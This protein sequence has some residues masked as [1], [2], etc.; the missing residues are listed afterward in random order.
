[1][2]AVHPTGPRQCEQKHT[3]TC[4]RSPWLTHRL[5]GPC[6]QSFNTIF[7][8]HFLYFILFYLIFWDGISLLLD[9]A[10]VQWCD[11]G[12]LQPPPPGSSNFPASASWVAGF[13]DTTHHAW[14]IFII[15]VETGFHHIGQAS[16][17]LLTS[18]DLSTS[19]SQSTGITGMSHHASPGNSTF[20]RTKQNNQNFKILVRTWCHVF[21]TISDLQRKF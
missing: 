9:Q 21:T 19:A 1:M 8:W 12:S 13:T 3:H 16:L 18:G 17:Q 10:G 20:L 7:Y 6:Y 14:L 2:T 11:L 4:R 15:L 5:T